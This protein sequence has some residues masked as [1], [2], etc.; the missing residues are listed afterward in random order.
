MPSTSPRPVSFD[1]R[2]KVVLVTGSNRGIG[3]S[4]IEGLLNAGAAKAYAGVRTLSSADKLVQTYGSDRV[5]PVHMDLSD[6]RTIRSAAEMAQDVELVVNNAGVLDIAEPPN[7]DGDGDG[8]AFLASLKNQME[9]NV[10]GLVHVA[11][12]FGPLLERRGGGA[13]VQI[14]STSSLRCPTP[15][16]A[17]Y[18]ASKSAAFSITQGLLGSLPNTRV[19]SVHPGPIATD[20]V[21]QFNGRDKSEPPEQVFEA[22][23]GALEKGDQFLVYTDTFSRGMGEDYRDFAQKHV[24]GT[25]GY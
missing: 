8:T 13:F 6:P 14:N 4:I 2:D 18:A 5:V 12:A 19:L 9:V 24:T 17:G 1:V 11:Q 21:D 10:F 23:V 15:A 22:I 16:F 7:G 20:M 25:P 3:L